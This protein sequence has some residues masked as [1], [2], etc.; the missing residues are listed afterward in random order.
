[1]SIHNCTMNDLQLKELEQKKKKWLLLSATRKK[2]DLN[3][4][5]NYKDFI[6]DRDNLKII[7][8]GQLKLI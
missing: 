5:A 6:F 7:K 8:K 1:M 4:S 3:P 2:K